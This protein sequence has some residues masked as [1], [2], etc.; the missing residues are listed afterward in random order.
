M[1]VWTGSLVLFIA[2]AV[3][4]TLNVVAGGGSFL[5]LPLL[6]FLGL[7]APIANATN[8][9]GVVAQTATSAFAFHGYGLLRW[10]M[11]VRW[12]LPVAAGA[13]L[14]AWAALHVSD[15]LFRRLLAFFMLALT[16]ATF[17]RRGGAPPLEHP[18][19]RAPAWTM[20]AFFVVGLYG[21]FIQAGVGFIVLAI[22]NTLRLDLVR[23]NAL[24]NVIVLLLTLLAL[25]LFAAQGAVNWP[26]GLALA[27]GN[28][29]GGLM[30]VRLAVAAGHRWLQ[31]IVTVTIVIFAVALLSGA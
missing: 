21:G 22:T 9:V 5:T 26:L 24:K 11:A 16:A 10:R 17:V 8:R 2:G 23:A 15:L 7:P 18:P 29:L 6:I 4:G 27:A 30:G 1:D 20:P 14:G 19:E 31:H 12:S 25:A 28:F 13:L 3:A